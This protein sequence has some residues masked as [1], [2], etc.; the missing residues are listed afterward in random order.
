MFV[1]VLYVPRIKKD[2]LSIHALTR[3]GLV[4]KFIDDKCIVHDLS[5]GDTIMALGSLCHGLYKLNA[6][7]ICVEDVA[8]AIVDT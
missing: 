6:Y 7:D 5:A 3:I 2:L 8:C 4:M 1:D